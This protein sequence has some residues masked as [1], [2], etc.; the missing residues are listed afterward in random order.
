MLD[1]DQKN[2]CITQSYGTK[3]NNRVNPMPLLKH[4]NTYLS[5]LGT[6]ECFETENLLDGSPS[7]SNRTSSPP[8]LLK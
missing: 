6:K 7:P 8:M 5:S 4:W 1:R 2:G 3:Q